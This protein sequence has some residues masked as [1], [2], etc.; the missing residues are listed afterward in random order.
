MEHFLKASRDLTAASTDLMNKSCPILLCHGVNDEKIPMSYCHYCY[1][2]LSQF[3]SNIKLKKYPGRIKY[4]F[5]NLL[6]LDS[7]I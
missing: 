5:L 3:Y 2:K 1:D 6:L 4:I 7:N